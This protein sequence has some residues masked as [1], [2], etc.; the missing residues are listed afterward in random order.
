MFLFYGLSGG[1][2]QRSSHFTHNP[3]VFNPFNPF[4]SVVK[5]GIRFRVR[6]RA[7]PLTFVACRQPSSLLHETLAVLPSPAS[8]LYPLSLCREVT[9]PTSRPLSHRCCSGC[10]EYSDEP[11]HV[12]AFRRLTFLCKE[13][14]DAQTWK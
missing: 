1:T 7:V 9:L 8:F 14:G 2:A 4:S 10:W 6:A 11:D 12:R 3:Q 13:T 5:S